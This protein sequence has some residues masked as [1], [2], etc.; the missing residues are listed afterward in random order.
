VK[1]RDSGEAS[2]SLNTL[3]ECGLLKGCERDDV[4]RLAEPT[5]PFTEE[6]ALD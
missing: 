2:A 6:V 5:A 1:L 4:Y 3:I